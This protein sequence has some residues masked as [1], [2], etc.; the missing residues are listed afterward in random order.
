MPEIHLP[1]RWHG[2]DYAARRLQE[3]KSRHYP[4][5]DTHQMISDFDWLVDEVEHLRSVADPSWRGGGGTD[6]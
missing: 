4:N 6:G 1:P 5:G 3:I 2:S